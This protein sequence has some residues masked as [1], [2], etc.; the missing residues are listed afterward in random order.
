MLNFTLRVEVK[1]TDVDNSVPQFRHESLP[2]AFFG[3]IGDLGVGQQ[4]Q[5]FE[6]MGVSEVGMRQTL[7]VL[8]R[9]IEKL[10]VLL[11][12]FA[13]DK[14]SNF[15]KKFEG[16]SMEAKKKEAEKIL[17]NSKDNYKKV[18]NEKSSVHKNEKSV[19]KA[20]KAS[21]NKKVAKKTKKVEK[22]EKKKVTKPK[23]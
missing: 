20:K 15:I 3:E 6:S 14:L 5:K 11:H 13:L 4:P 7:Y 2:V 9:H 22:K 23:K 8:Q 12:E 1:F 19:K 16:L 10:A 17:K 21:K 18:V